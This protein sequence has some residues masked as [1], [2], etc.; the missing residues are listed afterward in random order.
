MNRFILRVLT[1][2]G[3]MARA[4]PLRTFTR[5]ARQTSMAKQAKVYF[6][7]ALNFLRTD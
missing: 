7:A 4:T 2:V 3:V 6:K 1:G 5:W